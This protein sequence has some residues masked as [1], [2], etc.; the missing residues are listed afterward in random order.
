MRSLIFTSVT[1]VPSTEPDAEQVLNK[2]RG[3]DN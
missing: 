1:S 3:P 2:Q